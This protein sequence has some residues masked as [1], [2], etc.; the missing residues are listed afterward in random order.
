MN[1]ASVQIIDSS[2]AEALCEQDAFHAEWSRLAA[3]CPWATAFQRPEFVVRWYR[4]YRERFAPRLVVANDPAGGLGGLL[5]LAVDRARGDTVVAGAWQAEY[6]AW[7]TRPEQG[8]AFPRAAFAALRP[9]LTSRG[10]SFRY[11]PPGTPTGW[12]GA[13]ESRPFARLIPRHRPLMHLGDGSDV[14]ASLAKSSNKNRLRRLG[15]LGQ[16][17]FTRITTGAE[18]DRWMDAIIACYDTRR[19]ALN[20]VAPFRDDPFKRSFYG[21]LIA[22]PGLLHASVLTVGGEVAAAHLGAISG[23]E[24]QLGLLA[25]NPFLARHS[26]GKFLLL[27]LARAL[28]AEGF[29][30][31]DLTA[32]GE[33]YKERFANMADEVH[34]LDL[35]PGRLA[36]QRASIVHGCEDALKAALLRHDISPA[37]VKARLHEFRR[38]GLAAFRPVAPNA[39]SARPPL[40]YA[41]ETAAYANL[42]D[43]A[44]RRD[45]LEDLLDVERGPDGSS[46][47]AFLSAALERIENGDHVYT[48]SEGGVLRHVGWMRERVDEPERATLVPGVTLPADAA[49]VLDLFT[50]PAARRRGLATRVLQAMRRDAATVPGI[51]WLVVP[52]RPDDAPARSLVERLGFHQPGGSEEF[53]RVLTR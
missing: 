53:D 49:V 31:I 6:H 4:S 14:A 45:A 21:E 17:E 3:A 36:R 23:P 1:H 16:V 8:D 5:T 50:D 13:L 19:L 22:A 27:F 35:F 9:S 11:L 46:P 24:L 7:I 28:A 51:R 29:E 37:R 47:Q 43:G 18:F 39:H 48:W 38:R 33:P 40:L 2:E 41:S 32:G 20:G 30:R 34:T 52:V 12:L 44:V 10:L 42:D 25:H 15:K 26:P